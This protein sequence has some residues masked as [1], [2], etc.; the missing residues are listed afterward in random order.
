MNFKKELRIGVI[1]VI[2]I[3]VLYSLIE[4]W[5]SKSEDLGVQD[6]IIE[7]L[8]KKHPNADVIKIS[9]VEE[10]ENEE[11]EK[12]Y[13]IK[14]RITEG[15]TTSCPVR[16]HYHYNYPE[17]NFITQ[18]PEYIT[19]NCEVCIVEP[20][21]LAFEEQAIIGSHTLDGTQAIKEYIEQNEDAYVLV[22][23]EENGWRV[24]W[25]APSKNFGYDI[26]ISSNGEVL[27]LEKIMEETQ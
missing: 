21:T 24:V 17:Q 26:L 27:T 8:G 4:F 16:I 2:L 10:K 9:I 12:Y 3:L 25:T 6:F 5:G 7:D 23:K 18:P 14:A 22:T 1:L 20:C 19:E 11:G 13:Y 15:I